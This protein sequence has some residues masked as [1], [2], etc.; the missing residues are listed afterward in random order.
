MPQHAPYPVDPVLTAMALNYR[1]RRLIAD[2]VCPRVPVEGVAFKYLKHDVSQGFT[3]PDTQVGRRSKPN[4]V[5]YSASEETASVV[6]HGLDNPVPMSD[7]KNA[8][9][10]FDPVANGV[11]LT[12]GLIALA[13]EVR[14]ANMIF[15]ASNYGLSNKQTLSGTA[16]FNDFLNSSP[17][18][19]ITEALDS[20]IMRATE[21]TLGQGVAS[22]LKRHPEI[23]KA[24]NGNSGDVGIVPTAFLAELFEL[25]QVN[26]GLSLVNVSKKGEAR[27]LNKCWGNHISLQYK[28]PIS[29]AKGGMTHCFTGEFESRFVTNT[30]D[31]NISAHGGQLVRVVE[32]VKELVMAD[33]LGFL[34]QNAIA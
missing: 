34:I 19:V 24:Y 11:G 29:S 9:K 25:D 8:P 26:V 16:Q 21:I 3:V 33:D 12:T 10:N 2:D 32:Q 13:R 27:I 15:N 1:N 23:L 14:V 22:K 7:I 17:I 6:D 28:E 20:M 18:S 5:E 4:E 30:F 31:K